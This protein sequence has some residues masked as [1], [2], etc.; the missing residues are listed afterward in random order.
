MTVLTITIACGVCALIYGLWASQSILTSSAGSE[1]MQEDNV[2]MPLVMVHG[3]AGK[4]YGTSS[5]L[6]RSTQHIQ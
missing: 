3:V 5:N 2:E 6:S 4:K 1:K